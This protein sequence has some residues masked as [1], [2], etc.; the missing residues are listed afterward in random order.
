[1]NKSIYTFLVT[2]LIHSLLLPA[3]SIIAL[4][5][6][7]YNYICYDIFEKSLLDLFSK[8]HYIFIIF[9]L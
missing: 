5:L 1:M 3:I 7:H 4:P 6:F 8:G 2:N 9:Y